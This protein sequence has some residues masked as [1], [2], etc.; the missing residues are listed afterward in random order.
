MNSYLEKDESMGKS[1]FQE[2]LA[3]LRNIHF[4]SE[5]PLEVLKVFAY[6]C[7]RE[8]Y[9]R[10][11]II[12]SQDDDDGRAYCILSGEAGLSRIHEGTDTLIRTCGE[13][14][15]FGAFI[16]AGEVKRLFSLTALSDTCCL[17]LTRE[18]FHEVIDQFP[19]SRQ[20]IVTGIIENTVLWEEKF[21]NEHLACTSCLKN[22][23]VSLI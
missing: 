16:L 20:N 2:N 9:K 5:F 10:G 19:G 12:F 6:L 14:S 18:N 4:F 13:N 22:V 15:F 21:L 7:T 3:I 23:G 8:T 11:D 1:E 17:V